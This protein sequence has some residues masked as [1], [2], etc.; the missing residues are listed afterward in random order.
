VILALSSV[1]YYQYTTN[2]FVFYSNLSERTGLFTESKSTGIVFTGDLF[3]GRDVEQKIKQFGSEYPLSE[4]SEFFAGSDYVVTNFE[5][6]VPNTHVPT[7]S[8]SFTFSVATSSLQLLK[9]A[10][11][12]HTS[13]A[14]NHSDDF[15]SEGYFETRDNLARANLTPFGAPYS[16]GT[17]TSVTYVETKGGKIALIGMNLAGATFLE[18]EVETMMKEVSRVSNFQVFYVHWGDEYEPVH[19]VHQEEVARKLVEQ[20]AD[21]IVGHHP[22]VVQ[23][24]GLIDEVPVFYSLGN[25]IFDQYFSDAVQ[26]GLLLK[27]EVSESSANIKLFGTTSMGT[28]AQSRLLEDEQN[29]AFLEELSLKS[30]EFL[31]ESIATGQIQIAI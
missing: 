19:S 16:V 26:T 2:K 25:F 12:T 9:E 10:K 30:D 5:A 17:S 31:R 13:I 15:G 24:V 27:L 3:L 11:V 1:V 8:G 28:K 18:K 20:G 7:P 14:N 6:S 29:R 22:H 21:L 4:V 23:D